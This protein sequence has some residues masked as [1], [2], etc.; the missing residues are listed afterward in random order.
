MDASDDSVAEMERLLGSDRKGV[1]IWA[2]TGHFAEPPLVRRLLQT[3]PNLYCEL[4][5]RG[6]IYPGL[7]RLPIDTGGRLRPEWKALLEE[8]PDRFVLGTDVDEPIVSRYAEFVQFWRGVLSQ[9]SPETAGKIAY[10]N[11][12]RLLKLSP[13]R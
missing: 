7:T 13:T 9:L 12:E 10:Q 3:H 4:S 2:H 1:W 8:F 6:S 11:G 5:Y